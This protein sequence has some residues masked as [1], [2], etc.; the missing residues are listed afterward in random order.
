MDIPGPPLV[1]R[2]R[3]QLPTRLNGLS[4]L[5]TPQL[6]HS[7]QREPAQDLHG[8]GSCASPGDGAVAP[9]V[10]G[11]RMGA[12]TGTPG[13]PR[14]HR[15]QQGSPKAPGDPDEARGWA[16]HELQ[17]GT[18]PQQAWV[19][20][21]KTGRPQ[22]PLEPEAS[23]A[24]HLRAPSLFCDAAGGSQKWVRNPGWAWKRPQGD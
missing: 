16:G 19:F 22:P 20:P 10:P 12:Q 3:G 17:S 15:A 4:L 13:E 1:A 24:G 23:C 21:G 8:L 9:G 2:Q 14:P 18:Q 11:R 5:L 7:G 6:L